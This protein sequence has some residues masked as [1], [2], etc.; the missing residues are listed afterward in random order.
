[1]IARMIFDRSLQA[2]VWGQL[3]VTWWDGVQDDYGRTGPFV[4]HLYVHRGAPLLRMLVDF[5][6]GFAEGYTAGSLDFEGDL[7]DLVLFAY[8]NGLMT[9]RL[10]PRRID[11]LRALVPVSETAQHRAVLHH[12]NLGMDFFQQ[13][14]DDTMSYSCAYFQHP[15]ESLMQAQCNKIEY[16]LRKLRLEPGDSLLDLGC[17]WGHLLIRAGGAYAAHA[18]GITLS[19]QET[20]EVQRRIGR[21][22]MGGRVSVSCR[23]W[24]EHAGLGKRYDK[25]VC[26]GVLEHA[27]HRQLPDLLRTIAAMLRPGGLLLVECI[28]RPVEDD[29]TY[30]VNRDLLPLTYFPTLRELNI[31][32]TDANL[33]VHETENLR[34][35]FALTLDQWAMNFERNGEKIRGL[36]TS[37]EPLLERW[38]R[39]MTRDRFMRMWRLFLR[40]SAA[41]FRAGA[42]EVHQILATSGVSYKMPLT[43][44]DLYRNAHGALSQ[45]PELS[46]PHIAQN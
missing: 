20:G 44:Q 10:L 1:M 39:R 18:E 36:L 45:P 29:T 16:V 32:M 4:G 33:R 3:R 17:G 41:A 37:E 40:A 9:P 6:M 21:Y 26:L 46:R 11:L 13:L 43:R 7:H 42:L 30:W 5:E 12:Y 19:P 25:I 23:S 8:R 14:L 28:T 34:A 35:H 31:L 15:E 27:G 22:S 38:G 2:A 24:R